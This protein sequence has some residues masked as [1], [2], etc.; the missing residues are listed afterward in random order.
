MTIKPIKISPYLALSIG[1]LALSMT[2]I[3]V[4]WAQAPGTVTAVY[5]MGISAFAL[6]PFILKSKF[7]ITQSPSN[8]L[9]IVLIAGA[10]VALDHGTLSTAVGLT[11]IANCTLL[12]NIAPLWVALFALIIWREKLKKWFWIGLMLTITG[13]VVIFGSDL[14][15]H[16]QLGLGDGMAFLSSF[17]YAGY[18]LITQVG[19]KK[20]PALQ[21]IWSINLVSTIL[22]LVYNLV[23]GIPLT[24]YSIQ[25]YLVFAAAGLISQT[26]GYFSVTYALGHLPASIVAPTMVIQI[27]LTSLLAIPLTGESLSITQLIGGLA[28]LGGILLVNLTH[29]PHNNKPDPITE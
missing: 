16:P 18:F 8:W 2:S 24:G 13:A 23:S 28:V 1:I 22:L 25:T 19:R 20:L 26:V 21:Y 27:V 3:F 9:L 10:F 6:T 15:R 7:K 29:N 14:I 4:R 11:R 12:N 5:R 17:F